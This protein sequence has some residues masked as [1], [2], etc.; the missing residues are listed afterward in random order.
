[1]DANKR[2]SAEELLT[3]PFLEKAC[4][5]SKLAQSIEIV[6]LGNSLRMNGF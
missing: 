2:A 4:E 3:H 6:F 5:K 1:M